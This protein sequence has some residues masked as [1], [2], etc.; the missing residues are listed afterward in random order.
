[1]KPGN[2]TWMLWRGRESPDVSFVAGKGWNGTRFRCEITGEDGRSIF[3]QP[4]AFS[5]RKA[6]RIISQPPDR[7]LRAD[8]DVT[9]EVKAVGEGA[10]RYQWYYRKAGD[11]EWT[12]WKWHETSATSATAND[13]WQGMQLKCVITDGAGATVETRTVS[14]SI[15]DN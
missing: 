1:M 4:V 3:S 8:E 5:V 12:V 9:F 13:S 6:L 15:Y 7:S 2:D 11:E 10:L 14:I